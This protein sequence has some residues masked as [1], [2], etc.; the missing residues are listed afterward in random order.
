MACVRTKPTSPHTHDPKAELR[1]GSA[2][3]SVKGHFRP[4]LRQS[5]SDLMVLMDGRPTGVTWNYDRTELLTDGIIHGA[6]LCLALVGA[7]A[8]TIISCNTADNLKTASIFVYTAGLLIMLGLSAAYSLWPP[9]PR[10]W[11]LRRLDQS[12]IFL[13]I[14]ATYTPFI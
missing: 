11:L 2:A 4:A 1:I 8:L 14:A 3:P 5:L 13:F 10:K 7:I 12:A 9:S 6:G